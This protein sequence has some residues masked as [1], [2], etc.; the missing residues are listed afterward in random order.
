MVSGI[1]S[2]NGIVEANSND[3]TVGDEGI[4]EPEFTEEE[5]ELAYF[6]RSLDF[7]AVSDA[8]S[9]IHRADQSKNKAETHL[10]AGRIQTANVFDKRAANLE[11]LAFYLGKPTKTTKHT[12]NK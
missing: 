6:I 11:Q 5:K 9:G 8:V 12:F 2:P 4:N 1:I 3:D 10:R 7:D